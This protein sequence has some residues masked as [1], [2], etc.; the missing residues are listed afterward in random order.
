M[1]CGTDPLPMWLEGGIET[2]LDIDPRHQPDIVA[3]IADLPDV[4]RFDVVFGQ[5]CL[6]HLYPHQVR[7]ALAGFRRAL[8][9]GGYVCLFVPDLEDVQATEEPLFV[10]PCGPITGLDL[11][12]GLRSA[13]ESQPA[14]AHHCGFT[15]A[16]LQRELEQAGFERV[17]VKRLANYQLIGIGIEG[18]SVL[19]DA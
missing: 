6:E 15:Q 9:P 11:M 14:M 7:T 8:V 17:L 5:H 3:D 13:L 19:P 18:R 1:G 10:A 16:T 12:Y 2:R 4:G